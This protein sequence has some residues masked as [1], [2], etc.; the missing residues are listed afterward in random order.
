MGHGSYLPIIANGSMGIRRRG[1]QEEPYNIGKMWTKDWIVRKSGFVTLK[2]QTERKD[3]EG[4]V[5]AT[6]SERNE[7]LPLKAWHDVVRHMNP[8]AIKH[9]EERGLT[10][11]S[12]SIVAFEMKWSTWL[13]TREKRRRER[14]YP[15]GGSGCIRI[16]GRADVMVV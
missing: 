16:P 5:Y 8:R 2:R 14:C 6:P 4:V 3:G 15:Q 13:A 11:N 9:L 10:Q 12:D 1:I 7:R